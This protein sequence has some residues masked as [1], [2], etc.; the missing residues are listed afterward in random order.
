MKH[1]V[2]VTDLC[3]QSFQRGIC[4]FGYLLPKDSIVAWTNT[5]AFPNRAPTQKEA[6][7]RALKN[8]QNYG[9][10]DTVPVRWEFGRVYHEQIER[11]IPVSRW[12]R[13]PV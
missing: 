12:P 13:V 4:W 2:L 1:S 11:L 10:S 8:E 5:L 9:P 3:R 7:A 6:T